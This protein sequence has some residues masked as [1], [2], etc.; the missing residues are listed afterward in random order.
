MRNSMYFLIF[1]AI[2]VY[3]LAVYALRIRK[4]KRKDKTDKLI[5]FLVCI[6]ISKNFESFSRICSFPISSVEEYL[7]S[8]GPLRRKSN[9]TFSEKRK[10]ILL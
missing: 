4:L 10:T 2:T 6:L 8:K 9:E 7:L 5:S 3:V 1:F